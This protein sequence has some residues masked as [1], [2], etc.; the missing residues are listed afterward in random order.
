MRSRDG[1]QSWYHIKAQPRDGVIGG[2]YSDF[3]QLA[4]DGGDVN[5]RWYG[6]CN[7]GLFLSRDRGE[8][9]ATVGPWGM[10]QQMAVK[11]DTLT[12]NGS[13][14]V[15]S[16]LGPPGAALRHTADFGVS[17]TTVGNFTTLPYPAPDYAYPFLAVREGRLALAAAAPGDAYPHVYVSIDNGDS[18][19]AIDDA[20]DGTALASNI[21]GLEWDAFDSGK[22]YVS[23]AGRSVAI[24]RVAPT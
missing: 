1:G 22:L 19:T 23:T 5:A 7:F 12:G 17:W 24:V 4:L 15:L 8:T 21:M 6:N 13:V 3:G 10:W 16:T 14:W 18:W 2:I 20:R 9:W 11:P